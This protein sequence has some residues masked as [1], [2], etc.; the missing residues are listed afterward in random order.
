MFYNHKLSY[1]H[2]K[3]IKLYFPHL[4]LCRFVETCKTTKATID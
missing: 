2:M 1:V 4:V 3:A